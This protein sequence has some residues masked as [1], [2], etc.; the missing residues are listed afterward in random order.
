MEF[1]FEFSTH[2]ISS[3]PR[4]IATVLN[5]HFYSVGPDQ[6]NKLPPIHH[7]Y[8]DFFFFQS[9]TPINPFA[10]DLVGPK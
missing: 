8:V 2:S 3:D 9:Y 1:L 10:F 5:E 6:A 7:S 4:R